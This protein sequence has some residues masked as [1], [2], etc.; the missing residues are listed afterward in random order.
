MKN[1][2]PRKTSSEDLSIIGTYLWD[3]AK[4]LPGIADGVKSHVE[5]GLVVW[6]E[7]GAC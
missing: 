1:I 7:L 3:P 4:S 2:L 5:S 6:G